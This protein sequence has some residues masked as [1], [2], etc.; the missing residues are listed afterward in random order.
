MPALLCTIGDFKNLV[1]TRKDKNN[2]TLGF[3]QFNRLESQL[4]SNLNILT[5][6]LTRGWTYQKAMKAWVLI[7]SFE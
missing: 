5:F 6:S 2:K 1:T 7:G 3:L 4:N